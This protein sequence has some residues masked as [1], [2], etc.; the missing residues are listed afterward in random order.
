[1]DIQRHPE[2]QWI[3]DADRLVPFAQARALVG[4]SRSKVYAL[5]AVGGFPVPVKIGRNNYFSERE[6]QAWISEQLLA[7]GLKQND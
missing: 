2:N 3:S 4:L 1:M 6:L 5:L 7:R